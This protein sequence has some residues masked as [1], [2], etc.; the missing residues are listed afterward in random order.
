[1]PYAVHLDLDAEAQAR[2]APLQAV[3]ESD[4]A[5]ETPRRLGAPLHLSLAV[6]DALPAEPLAPRLAAFAQGLAPL[7]LALA[8]LGLF[9]GERPVAF[10]GPLVDEPLLALHRRFHERFADLAAA[11]W[12]HYRPGQWVPHVTIAMG[13][14]AASLATGLAAIA[15]GWTPEPARLDAIGLIR[16]RPVERLWHADLG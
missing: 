5:T 16:F 15:R 8:Q 13:G 7:P 2:L 12:P 3:F 9:P 4:A 6:Y 1:M 10:L 14:D 11:C